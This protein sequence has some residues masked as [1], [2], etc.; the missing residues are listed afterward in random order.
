MSEAGGQRCS[1]CGLP[2]GPTRDLIH[3]D[4]QRAS[5]CLECAELAAR[6]LRIQRQSA[7][8]FWAPEER[9]ELSKRLG[10][11]LIDLSQI[12]PSKEALQKLGKGMAV[13]HSVLPIRSVGALLLAV[14]RAPEPEVLTEIQDD[15]GLKIELALS[16]QPDIL[17][18]IEK[19]YS[20]LADDSND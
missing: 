3:A 11:P 1:F 17:D 16:V 14:S 10:I 12:S 2:A 9:W 6:H 5:I 8:A 13:K 7:D 19:Y 4:N 18:W 20:A 15:L